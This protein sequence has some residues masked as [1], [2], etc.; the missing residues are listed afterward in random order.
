MSIESGSYA[1]A[2]IKVKCKLST[3]NGVYGQSN[4]GGKDKNE[5]HLYTN[6][7]IQNVPSGK[8]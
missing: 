1:N 6:V 8:E 3:V 5:P 7:C 2:G 4:I